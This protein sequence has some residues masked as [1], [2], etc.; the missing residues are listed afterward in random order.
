METH[1]LEAFDAEAAAFARTLAPRQDGATIV[2]LSGELGAGKTTFVQAVARACGVQEPVQ[3]PTF[4]IMQMY[5]IADSGTGFAR[6]I[7]IDAYRLN[8]AH[9]IEILGWKELAADPR[10]LICIEWPEQVAGVVPE[11]AQKVTLEG[12]GDSRRIIY[13]IAR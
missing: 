10:N 11:T 5:D 2:A 3:S 7:H 12:N 8:N 6:L 9:D 13:G 4:V 1:S